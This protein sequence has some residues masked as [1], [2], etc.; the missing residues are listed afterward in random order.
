MEKR[1]KGMRKKTSS[2]TFG[3]FVPFGTDGVFTDMA[4]GLDL[5]QELKLGG[6]QQVTIT[7][8]DEDSTLI[9][10]TYS[11]SK[12]NEI[13]RVETLVTKNEREEPV[14]STKLYKGQE[15]IKSKSISFVEEA[16]A[17]VITEALSAQEGGS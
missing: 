17:D 7:E 5:E 1:V 12:G 3:S 4:S 9:V 10:E 6:N 8:P 15:L 14:V 13:Y 11:D 16:Q 2:S